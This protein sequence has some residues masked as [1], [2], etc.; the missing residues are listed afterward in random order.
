MMGI[1]LLLV[2][3]MVLSALYY[4]VNNKPKKDEYVWVGFGEDPFKR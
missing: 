2:G 3:C 4:Y 1:T